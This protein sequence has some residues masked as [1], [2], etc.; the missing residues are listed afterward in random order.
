MTTLYEHPDYLA[1]LAAIR[2][3]PDDDLPRKVAADWLEEH[4]E[5]DRA[6]FIRVQ[7]EKNVAPW[8]RFRSGS[9]CECTSCRLTRRETALLDA[10]GRAWFTPADGWA[11]SATSL[12]RS[13]APG[14]L[15]RRGFVERVAGPLNTLI[16]EECGRCGGVGWRPQ[17]EV[18]VETGH[19]VEIQCSACHGTGRRRGVLRGLV[20]REPVRIAEVT[21]RDP[22]RRDVMYPGHQAWG[23]DPD[24]FPPEIH[25]AIRAVDS[26]FGELPGGPGSFLWYESEVGLSAKDLAQFGLSRV[27][28]AWAVAKDPPPL[29]A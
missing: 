3:T 9:G 23:W 6:E 1:L 19:P 2:A 13:E 7:V 10:H 17:G 24:Q 21:D 15:V 20:R 22:V 4:G 29:P 26:H 25:E 18:D 27:L 11:V 12:T 28:L 14:V 8:C 5:H 16:G